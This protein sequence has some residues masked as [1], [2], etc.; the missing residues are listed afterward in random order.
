[1]TI[2]TLKQKLK[3]MALIKKYQLTEKSSQIKVLPNTDQKLPHI[4]YPFVLPP[5]F[6]SASWWHKNSNSHKEY[7]HSY[8]HTRLTRPNFVIPFSFP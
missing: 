3:L 2:M 4:A 8:A 5:K 1:M 6:L 7:T